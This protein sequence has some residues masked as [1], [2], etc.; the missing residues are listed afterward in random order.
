MRTPEPPYLELGFYFRQKSGRE[1]I[2]FLAAALTTHF[3][4][5]PAVA[6]AADLGTP[7]LFRADDVIGRP[8]KTPGVDDLNRLLGDSS[9][10]VRKINFDRG[11]RIVR[12]AQEFLVVLPIEGAECKNEGNAVAIWV[13][14]AAFSRASNTDVSKKEKKVASNSLSAFKKLISHLQPTY[15]AITVDYGLENPC[16]LRRDPRSLAFRDFYVSRTDFGESFLTELRTKFPNSV[17]D[18]YE[19]GQITITTTALR[20]AA[21]SE[22]VGDDGY[23]LS[24]FV[25]RSIGSLL[26]L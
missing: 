6:Y 8:V 17:Y 7:S 4:A 15:A 9:K 22:S 20:F 24:E 25:G 1:A 18:D 14:G 11:T 21:G 19:G 13:E 16:D 23:D 12:D 5:V 3:D 10:F 26:T 2:N